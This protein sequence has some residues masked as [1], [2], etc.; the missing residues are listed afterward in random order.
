M[1]SVFNTDF[2]SVK[3]HTGGYQAES[4]GALAFTTGND[5]YFA[6]GYYNP[7]TTHGQRL[8]GHEL[9]HVVQQRNGRV[10]N[11]FEN[12]I[13]VVNDPGL[14]AEAERM[15]IKS[16]TMQMLRGPKKLI[17]T[18]FS[19]ETQKKL[20]L[21]RGQHRRHIISHH[22]IKDALQ[23]LNDYHGTSLS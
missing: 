4:I 15:S 8:L 17:R 16:Q 14:E 7:N 22:H 3:I 9:T 23:I 6:Q 5:I 1:E 13:T 11:P 21:K 20:V 12:G 19:K 10:R 18:N 2:S